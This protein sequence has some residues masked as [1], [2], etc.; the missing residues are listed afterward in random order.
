M[1]ILQSSLERLALLFNI[2]PTLVPID[3]LS[4]DFPK[5]L[6]VHIVGPLLAASMLTFDVHGD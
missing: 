4:H 5:S 6:L 2:L 1:M 3:R